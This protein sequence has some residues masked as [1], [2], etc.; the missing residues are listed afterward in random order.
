VFGIGMTE[1]LVILVVGLLVL[2][3]KRLP[4]L[5]RSLG[6]GLAEFRRASTDMRREF[7][8]VAEE[9]K[10]ETPD[11]P[12]SWVSEKPDAPAAL[13]DAPPSEGADSESDAAERI[14]ETKGG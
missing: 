14:A 1:L 7:L 11:D 3:P 2:G 9:V 10:R 12:A 5:A 8:D 13:A 4:E 6:R